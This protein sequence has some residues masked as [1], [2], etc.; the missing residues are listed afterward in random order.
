MPKTSTSLTTA[1]GT[2]WLG[3]GRHLGPSPEQ[4]V[5]RNLIA[6][7][8]AGVIDDFLD[9]DPSDTFAADGGPA[10]APTAREHAPVPDFSAR[11]LF[12][13]RW[14]VHGDVTVRAQLRCY[15]LQGR[16]GDGEAAAWTLAAKAER[17]WDQRW[18]SPATMFWP[19]DDRTAW[20][21]DP[22]AG[23]R[24]RTTNR[25]PSDDKEMRRLLKDCTRVSWNVHVVV[26]EAMTPDARGRRPLAH[27]LPPS[28]RHRVVEHRAAPEQF[29][30]VNW[31]MKDLHVR[32]PRGGAVVLP[33]VP[34]GPGYDAEQFAV[35]SVFLDGSEPTELVE[36]VTA[37]ADL[38]RALT[39]EAERVLDDLC[40][41]WHLLT[42]EEELTH[43]RELVARYA[44][45]LEAMT[46]SRDLYREAAELAQAA[47]AEVTG[48]DSLPRP[49]SS[50][51]AAA[52]TGS[53]RTLLTKALGRF[54]DAS[55][56]DPRN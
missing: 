55:K 9:L 45:A 26:H 16:P 37:F 28:L 47:L 30:I 18:P 44:E 4:D 38:P 25:L 5:R 32:V 43:A 8:A 49:P 14:R 1:P 24:L 52:S 33:T 41:H 56:Q 11:R 31:A 39:A 50:G 23:L 40:H 35:R 3:H 19:D 53:P 48:S 12:E 42:V 29:Q 22:V 54:K 7:K 13:A 34:A 10:A 46:R 2:T 27:F 15:D 51:T 21:H 36:K 17:M 20:D 6:L